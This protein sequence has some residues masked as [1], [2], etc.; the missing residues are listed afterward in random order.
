[1]QPTV[2]HRLTGILE[3]DREA[4]AWLY[5][6]FGPRLY[7]RLKQRYSYPGG[8]DGEDLLQ[9]A[10]LFFFQNDGRVLRRFLEQV[11]PQQQTPGQLE[12]YLWDLACGVA[13]N[14]RRSAFHRRVVSLFDRHDI[15]LD[16][17]AE[18]HAIDRDTVERL[19]DCLREGRE[20]VFLY[21]VLRYKDGLAPEEVAAVC[22]WSR[23]AT[24]KLKQLL[25]KAVATCAR[26]LGIEN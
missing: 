15:P 9:D 26:L 5:D 12:T 7:R 25:D 23:K 20:R 17:L 6:T 4:S 14:R 1:M 10:F 19:E 18:R 8:L 22:G 13:S 16:P 3:G 11:P 21:Y 2:R 24:Y